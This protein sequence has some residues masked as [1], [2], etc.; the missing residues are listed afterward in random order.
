MNHHAEIKIVKAT[1]FNHK[2]LASS[3]FFGWRTQ[4][5]KTAKGVA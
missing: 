4:H 1:F 3:T 2:D 5:N